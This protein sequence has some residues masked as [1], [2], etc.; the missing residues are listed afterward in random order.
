MKNFEEFI[1]SSVKRQ[2][3][4][5]PK[6]KSL[7]MQADQR[8]KF[9]ASIPKTA[10]NANYIVENVYDVIREL[11]EAKLA[12]DGFKSYS[13]EAA[14]AYMQVLGFSEFE[15]KFTNELR[16][17]RHGIKYKGENTSLEYAHQTITFLE[18]V[19]PKL[20]TLLKEVA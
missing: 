13:H 8:V 18:K 10:E 15:V 2:R 1:G 5:L 19:M 17:I 12:I 14:V 3:Q 9:I 4:E 11:L 16:K 6:A 20:K 7:V